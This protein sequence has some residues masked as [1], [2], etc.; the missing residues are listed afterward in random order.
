MS[1]DERPHSLTKAG[2]EQRTHR[3]RQQRDIRIPVVD[4]IDDGHSG[5]AR[6]A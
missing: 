2:W 5:L 1:T 6:P 3:Q 4:V